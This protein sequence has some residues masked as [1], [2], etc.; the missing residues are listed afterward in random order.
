MLPEPVDQPDGPTMLAPVRVWVELKPNFWMPKLLPA[1]M[2]S[3][4]RGV[5]RNSMSPGCSVLSE[6]VT[7]R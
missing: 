2:V 5:T 3:E 6:I 7:W 4:A 1:S